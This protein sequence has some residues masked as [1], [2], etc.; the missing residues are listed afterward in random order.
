MALLTI[1]KKVLKMLRNQFFKLHK[2]KK[3]RKVKIN[4]D[5]NNLC[6]MISKFSIKCKKK[7]MK[8]KNLIFL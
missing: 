7:E 1:E 4:D 3:I 2:L 6:V 5:F 8:K